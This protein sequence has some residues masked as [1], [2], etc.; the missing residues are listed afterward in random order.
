M[1]SAIEIVTFKL[2]QGVTEH[3]LVTA[4]EQSQVFVANLPGF[5]YRSLSYEIERNL[6]NDVIY[7][8]SMEE[9]KQASKQFAANEQCQA[10]I[11]LIDRDSVDIQH[12]HIKMCDLAKKYR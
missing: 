12:Q 11:A 7:W 4:S 10:L 3:D 9:A 6:W 1:Q 8:D 2:R 5:Q